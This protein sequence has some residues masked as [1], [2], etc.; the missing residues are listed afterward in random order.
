MKNINDILEKLRPGILPEHS[1]SLLFRNRFLL[2]II[3]VVV[4]SMGSLI[5]LPITISAGY[6]SD[7]RYKL[8]FQIRLEIQ[9][10]SKLLRSPLSEHLFNN[11]FRI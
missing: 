8:I 7:K 6:I 9:Q 2:R 1:R 4:L 10:A 11:T 3:M 5:Y